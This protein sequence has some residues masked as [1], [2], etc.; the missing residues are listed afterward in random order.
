M[1]HGARVAVIVP[2]YQEARLIGRTLRSLPE[3]VDQVHVVDDASDDGTSEAARGVGDSRVRIWRHPVNRG[4]GAAIVT[5]YHAALAE[6]ADVLAVMAGDAQMHPDDLAPLLDPVVHG[7]CDYAKGNRFIHAEARKMPLLRRTAGSA[8]ALFTRQAFGVD[9]DDSQCGF[10]AISAAALRQLDLDDLWPR[11]GYP[12]DLI[13]MLARESLQV[14]DVAVRPVYAD[15]RSGV[16]PWHVLSIAG[17][18]TR[19]WWRNRAPLALPAA[20][21]VND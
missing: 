4:V 21:S 7:K 20:T 12:N 9:I 8:L 16:R 19:R 14:L 10:T 17:I 6:L 5:G 11:F 2:A 18:I 1:W 3:Y 13:G 15:E